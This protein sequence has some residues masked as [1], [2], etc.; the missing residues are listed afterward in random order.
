M[1]AQTCNF[2]DRLREIEQNLA[3][4]P[5]GTDYL[6]EFPYTEETFILFS[7]PGKAVHCWKHLHS[8]LKRFCFRISWRNEKR[9]PIFP[10]EWPW[11]VS[12]KVLYF[13]WMIIV[14]VSQH[15]YTW[16][17]EKHRGRMLSFLISPA[18]ALKAC[19]PRSRLKCY[20]TSHW[21]DNDTQLRCEGIQWNHIHQTSAGNYFRLTLFEK[22][23]ILIIYTA[24]VSSWRCVKNLLLRFSHI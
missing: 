16:G 21:W 4:N 5:N 10:T 23:R 8:T 7:S 2:G 19:S 22:K 1:T 9:T 17:H 15:Q 12:N 13:S 11:Q 3:R 20:H 6:A 18:F 24:V 14:H